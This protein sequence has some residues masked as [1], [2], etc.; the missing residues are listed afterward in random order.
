MADY[1]FSGDIDIDQITLIGGGGEVFNIQEQFIELN[2]YQSIF[3]KYLECDVYINDALF[4]ASQV[5]GSINDNI[6]GGF[7]GIETLVVKYR[8]RTDPSED[9]NIPVKT[10]VF[11]VYEISD[12]KREGEGTEKY[13]INGI[14]LEAYR[15]LPTRI[16]KVYGK[17]RGNTISKMMESL[18]KEYVLPDELKNEYQAIGLNKQVNIDETSGM[19]NYIIPNKSVNETID[20]FCKEADS[21]DHYPYYMFYEDSNGYNFRNLPFLIEDGEIDWT[22]TY[23]PSNYEG[24]DKDVEGSDQYKIISF[25]VIQENSFLEN[26]KGGMFKSKSVGID[27][28]RKKKLEKVF[29]Y[30]KEQEN[31]YTVEGGYFPVEVNAD[32]VVNNDYTTFGHDTDEF[33]NNDTTVMS[34][35]DILT[36]NRVMSYNKQIFNNVVEVMI[37]GDSTKNVGGLIDLQFYINNTIGENKYE[38]DKTLSGQY[39]IT[40]V[41]QKI[42]AENFVTIMQCCKDS[43]ML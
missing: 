18:M 16:S 22:Y 23:Y 30:T 27:I 42:N 15:T 43:A 8:E 1:N 40:K 32:G 36:K 4:L 20:F 7:K 2:I 17:G 12:R 10:H 29:D 28:L 39:L 33:F 14:S 34:K 5:K 31:F 6:P 9:A 13:L 38:V 41:R 21:K 11:G 26:L 19:K 35:K 24:D 25:N 37:A 3:K